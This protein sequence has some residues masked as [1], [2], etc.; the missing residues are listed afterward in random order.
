MLIDNAG[1]GPP[2]RSAMAISASAASRRPASRS[3]R[4]ASSVA[5]S[6]TAR[7]SS[8]PLTDLP[9]PYRLELAAAPVASSNV[10]LFHKTTHRTVYEQAL[11]D[12]EHT[13]AFTAMRND[14]KAALEGGDRPRL[15]LEHPWD[16]RFIEFMPFDGN[17]WNKAKMVSYAEVMTDVNVSF[18]DSEVLRI[19][20]APNDTSKN[21][22]IKDCLTFINTI[23]YA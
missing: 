2:P 19:A 3:A 14:V 23:F 15:T 18:N 16:V 22:R 12:I 17:Q 10:F 5:V 4:T 9:Q 6:S 20:D 21:Y 8:T 13:L 7:L 1:S 11:R